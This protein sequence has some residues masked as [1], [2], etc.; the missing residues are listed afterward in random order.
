MASII[1]SKEEL[2]KT[3]NKL[4][5]YKSLGRPN[6]VPPVTTFSDV[7][8]PV[9]ESA[10]REYARSHKGCTKQIEDKAWNDFLSKLRKRI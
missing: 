7:I 1:F 6:A 5:I 10:F 3:K 9:I 8:I 4:G 2:N